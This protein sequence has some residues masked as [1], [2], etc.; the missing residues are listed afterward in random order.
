MA[1]I[2]AFRTQVDAFKLGLQGTRTEIMVQAAKQA[3]DEAQ[4]TNRAALG[5]DPAFDQIVDGNRG[6]ALE[7]VK[8]GGKIV[9]LFHVGAATLNAAIDEAVSVFLS[10][11]P[12]GTPPRD[13]HPGLYRGSLVLL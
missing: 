10:I 6:A 12:V 1:R 2:S 4:R 3:F 13:D 5:R 11:A 9:Y 8:P 7:S